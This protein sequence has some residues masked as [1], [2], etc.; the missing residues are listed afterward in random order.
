LFSPS[1]FNWD[2][3]DALPDAGGLV[4]KTSLGG[5]SSVGDGLSQTISWHVGE[6]MTPEST[7]QNEVSVPPFSHIDVVSISLLS[8]ASSPKSIVEGI[9]IERFEGDAGVARKKDEVYGP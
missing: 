2:V 7:E 1:L 3:G 9:A 6:L 4:T 8:S 5:F